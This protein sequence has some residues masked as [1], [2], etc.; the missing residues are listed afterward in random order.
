MPIPQPL[1][2]LTGACSV[3]YDNVLYE[4]SSSA[5]QS[6]SLGKGSEWLK[7]T[8]GQ[9][10]DGAVCVGSTPSNL[11]D[12]G[13]Y[14]VGGTSS[15]SNYTGLQ[16]YTYSTGTWATITPQATVTQDRIWHS[17][18]Y[19][20]GSDTIL[21]YAGSQQ[22]IQSLS[23]QTYTIGA[24]EPYTVLSY[25]SAAPP[26]IAP[27]LLPWSATEA[28]VIGG[29]SLNTK[30]MLFD[31]ARSW[32]DSNITL[33]DP[34][35]KNTT[36][37]KGAIVTGTDGSKSLYTFDLGITPNTVNRT[38]LL[39]GNGESITGAVA[40]QGTDSGNATT[41]SRRDLATGTWP[42]YNATYVPDVVRTGYSLASDSNG[43][44]VISGG[45][46]SGGT[47]NDLLCVFQGTQNSWQNAT[48]MLLGKGVSGL[49]ATPSSITA[50]SSA[51][52]APSTTVASTAT[53]VPT[54]AATT[55][56]TSSDGLAPTTILAIA[57]GVIFGVAFVLVALLFLVKRKRQRQDFVDAGH[58][59]RAS[60]IPGE[61]DY[62]PR[63]MAEAT[64]QFYPGHSQ[65][66]SQGSFSSMAILMG[67][68]HQNQQAL[69]RK[70]SKES[71][72]SSAGS[73]LNKQFKSTIGRP[74][75]IPEPAVVAKDEKAAITFAAIANEPKPRTGPVL[76]RDGERRSSGWNRYWSGG[77]TLNAVGFGS[78]NGKRETQET[79]RSSVY[80]E[81]RRM[82]QDSATVPALQM[83]GRPE[84]N[85]VHSASPR[86]SH[87]NDDHLS[88]GQSGQIERP[89][90]GASSS[91]YSS[92]IPASVH[93]S[94]ESW[95]PSTPGKVW[96]Q[97]RAPSSA[98][99]QSIYPTPLAA[100]GPSRVPSAH[101]RQPQLRQPELTMTS[102]TS[103][104]SWLNLGDNDGSRRQQYPGAPSYDRRY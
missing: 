32:Y 48:A 95:D 104:M 100:P 85:R 79:D 73:I 44:I 74:E 97:N 5:F 31:P 18:T 17:A 57:L 43:M 22:G 34:L 71:K 25:E 55:S 101:T 78:G 41:E 65:Q 19:L 28:V 1:V 67:K 70:G 66:E 7:L 94:R 59:R 46:I 38:L 8:A 103:D 64:G 37:V 86:V 80:S 91:G 82:T 69:N 84:F 14:V 26:V 23:S 51:T 20:N 40:I 90:S 16:K 54:P 49:S 9:P 36:L 61:K 35:P 77:S 4:Y 6:L 3:I 29:D 42:E 58:A 24:S 53:S 52:A 81:K 21:V 47:P 99:S 10:V 96:G 45:T 13:M 88:E 87:T 83:E 72:R 68:A 60:G 92:G 50:A 62:L 33:A 89:A 12:A 56:L 30:V 11:S 102:A 2:A 39:N 63:D 98:Y 93:D 76:T 15:D 27:I 75:L